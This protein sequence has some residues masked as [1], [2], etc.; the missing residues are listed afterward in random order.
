MPLFECTKCG[1]MDNTA[2]TTGYWYAHSKGRPVLCSECAD[3]K[4]HGQF[5][6]RTP[7]E[8]GYEM[9]PHGLQRVPAGKS[10]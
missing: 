2:L 3:G 1:A 4:W 6:K 7:K 5:P 8:A 9:G 10:K